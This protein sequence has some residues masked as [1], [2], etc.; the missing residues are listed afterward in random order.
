[1]NRVYKIGDEIIVHDPTPEMIPFLYGLDP[2]F[3][4]LSIP[5]GKD[6]E[7]KFQQ[8]KNQR[9]SFSQNLFEMETEGL[10]DILYGKKEL[11]SGS[12]IAHSYTM[13][14]VLH[15]WSLNSISICQLC[16]WNC[17]V[18]RF[19]E[20]GKCGLAVN[21]Y[22][23][24]PFVHIAEE[25]IINPAIVVNLGG[26]SMRCC[27]C[28]DSYLWNVSDLEKMEPESFWNKIDMFDKRYKPINTLQFANPTESI[29]GIIHVLRE[30]PD[31]FKKPIV[32]NAH[33]YGSAAF[34]EIATRIADV[35]LV[36][37]RYGNDICAKNLSGIDKYMDA[38]LAG[39]EILAESGTKVIVRILVLPGHVA[40]CHS[41]AIEIFSKYKSAFDLAILNQYIPENENKLSAG[42]KRRPTG[43]ELQ[44]VKSLA[45][46]EGIV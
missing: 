43:D 28:I 3:K 12:S 7:P 10:R 5:P 25:P 2:E 22:Y 14:D 37:L 30:A 45:N 8:L 1:M 40:C 31:N 13:L 41:P 6:F 24:N 29:S 36:D 23:S 35:W 32:F 44:A 15:A 11:K 38:A 46:K 9:V 42:L 27:Y 39:L 17:K 18:N 33:L 16:G 26:C 4:V 19:R 21:A 20:K 34:Y